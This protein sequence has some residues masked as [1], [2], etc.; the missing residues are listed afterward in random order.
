MRTKRG[1]F[2]FPV[3]SSQC[4]EGRRRKRRAKTT[5]EE[6]RE[7]EE[8]VVSSPLLSLVHVREVTSSIQIRNRLLLLF[9]DFSWIPPS[10]LFLPS[11]RKEEKKEEEQQQDFF[12]SP[13]SSALGE[14]K[15]EI[16]FS[17]LILYPSIS[18]SVDLPHLSF[19]F[20]DQDK[21]PLSQLVR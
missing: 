1:Q 21:L 16:F 19:S 6:D 11:R 9:S 17:P 5:N 20:F 8:G 3:D 10:L 2:L 13:S 4:A 15:G 7:K 14:K 12:F 18:L